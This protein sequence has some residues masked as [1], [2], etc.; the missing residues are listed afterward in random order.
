VLCISDS[1]AEAEADVQH[2][3]ALIPT[4]SA[5]TTAK[6]PNIV[7]HPLSDKITHAFFCEQVQPAP[8]TQGPPA[9]HVHADA[10]FPHEQALP[11]PQAP[12]ARHEHA[13][14]AAFSLQEQVLPQPQAPPVWHE[15]AGD[16]H[17]Q[18]A[19]HEHAVPLVWQVHSAL[20]EHEHDSPHEQGAP[21]SVLQAQAAFL[22]LEDPQLQV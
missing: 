1:G 17:L 7:I 8:Q 12:P 5:G 22:V 19:P 10:D 2:Q 13:A 6:S 3:T 16:E 15:H 18:L 14:L 9:V 21:A 11:Q 20:D 4:T